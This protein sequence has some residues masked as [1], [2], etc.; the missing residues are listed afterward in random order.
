[1]GC[2]ASRLVAATANTAPGGKLM[3]VPSHPSTLLPENLRTGRGFSISS[4]ILSL[5]WVGGGG[6]QTLN[7]VS[8]VFLGHS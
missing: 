5:P 4:L 7:I 3:V 6:S 8:L 1:M 2:S